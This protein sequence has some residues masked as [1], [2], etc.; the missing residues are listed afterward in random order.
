MQ[1]DSDEDITNGTEVVCKPHDHHR[2]AFKTWNATHVL[3]SQQILF[4]GS[5]FCIG[6][7]CIGALTCIELQVAREDH[8]PGASIA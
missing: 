2:D 3:D 8:D 1:A 4:A 5:V 7:K 6:G